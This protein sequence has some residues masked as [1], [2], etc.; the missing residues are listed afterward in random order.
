MGK[1]KRSANTYQKIHSVFNRDENNIIMP[2]D[3][4]VNPAL[5]YL[6]DVKMYAT[7]K[8]DGTNIRIEVFP[9]EDRDL[10]VCESPA[11]LKGVIYTVN[12]KGKTDNA[13][14]PPLL[15]KHLQETFITSKVLAA[16]NLAEYISVEEFEE[17]KWI[18]DGVA[19]APR[20]TIYGEGYGKSIQNGARYI[21]DKTGFILFDVKVNELYLLPE[22]AKEIA[23]KLGCP[24][25]PELEPMS[26]NEAIE[27][28]KKTFL[29][30]VSEDPTLVAEGV[31]LKTPVGLVDRSGKR[32][33]AKVKCED[34]AKYYRKY[35]TF[36]KVEQRKNPK[37]Q[38][39][40]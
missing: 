19:E 26:I 27:L 4:L 23:Q 8:I 11:P 10:T 13:S 1:Q 35:G 32:I 38:D 36:D 2:Y 24:Y 9:V 31:V 7:E 22:A 28:C 25:V 29:S 34:F 14:I 33:I 18:K 20:Y 5:E 39:A 12:F 30:K 6:R 3:G 16:L 40:E 15:L 21:K 17:R 37:Y